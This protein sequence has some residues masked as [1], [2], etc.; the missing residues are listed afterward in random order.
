MD[1]P[2][3]WTRIVHEFKTKFPHADIHLGCQ[4][5]NPHTLRV[6]S[7]THIWIGGLLYVDDLL[8][9]YVHLVQLH[10]R[11]IITR[12]DTFT[13]LLFKKLKLVLSPLQPA[14]LKPGL[15]HMIRNARFHDRP[16]NWPPPS[17]GLT[18]S[19]NSERALACGTRAF[20]PFRQHTDSAMI[21]NQDLL[22]PRIWRI[23]GFG[24]GTDGSLRMSSSHSPAFGS[25]QY[26]ALICFINPILETR[27]GAGLLMRRFITSEPRDARMSVCFFVLFNRHSGIDTVPGL[28]QTWRCGK[29]HVPTKWITSIRVPCLCVQRFLFASHSKARDFYSFTFFCAQCFPIRAPFWKA[30]DRKYV[31]I[32]IQIFLVQSSEWRLWRRN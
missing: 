8:T 31:Y 11:L 14:H 15:S 29:E 22:F 32:Y 19:Q 21:C 6:G 30:R 16:T 28:P 7:T 3:Y 5:P 9:K 10:F 18:S 12:P 27:H 4:P 17:H 25:S 13:A 24:A 23:R 1:I 2:Y 26:S 20:G